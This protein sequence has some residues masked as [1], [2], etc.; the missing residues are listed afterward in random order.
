MYCSTLLQTPFTLSAAYNILQYLI[1]A[2]LHSVSTTQCSAVPYYSLPSLCQH[3]TNYCNTSLQPPF[4][5]SAPQ[6]V[7]QYL[8]TNSLH[9]VSTTQC[10][11]V[12]HY[13]LPSL[14]QH[15]TIYCSTSLQP[16]FTLSA[17]HNTVMH[18][19]ECTAVPN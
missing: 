1:T 16:P 14:C 12:A 7:L 10:T 3:H 11:A 6:N 2:S 4:T 13:S 15:H 5:L 17:P 8:I 19:S 18:K 9:S